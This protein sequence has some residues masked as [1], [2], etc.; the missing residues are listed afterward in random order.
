MPGAGYPSVAGQTLGVTGLDGRHGAVDTNAQ[1]PAGRHFVRSLPLTSV[2]EIIA[3]A[4]Q[5]R[6][7]RRHGRC[8]SAATGGVG[9]HL[10]LEVLP[11]LR[12]GEIDVAAATAG[13]ASC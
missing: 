3:A 11:K 4:R 5:G 1:L 7:G 2:G 13:V 6:Q 10:G 9:W 12:L 8:A